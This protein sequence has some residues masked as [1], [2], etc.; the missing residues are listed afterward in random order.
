MPPYKSSAARPNDYIY[1]KLRFQF[2]FFSIK[3][4]YILDPLFT[5]SGPKDH[6]KAAIISKISM[7]KFVR[8]TTI[9]LCICFFVS[10]SL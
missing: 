1:G 9:F 10:F 3:L 5:V 7:A 2:A 6:M 4:E 8:N